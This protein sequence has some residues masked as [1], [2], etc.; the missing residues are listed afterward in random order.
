MIFDF[1]R[2]EDAFSSRTDMFDF[3]YPKY[4]QQIGSTFSYEEIESIIYNHYLSYQIC[5]KS[6]VKWKR[7]YL[8]PRMNEIMRKYN[9][10][11]ETADMIVEPLTNRNYTI[12]K[13]FT[14]TENTTGSKDSTSEIEKADATSGYNNSNF[15]NTKES[16]DSENRSNT[17]SETIGVETSETVTGSNSNSKKFSDTPQGAVTNLTNGYLTNVTLDDGS[18]S[19]STSGSSDTSNSKSESGETTSSSEATDTGENR[20]NFL[21][22]NSGSSNK[23]DSETTSKENSI[24]HESFEEIKGYDNMDAAKLLEDY[25][26]TIID[27]NTMLINDLADL[28]MQVYDYENLFEDIFGEESIEIPDDLPNG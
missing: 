18:N 21:T 7:Y 3:N 12:T 19:E 23:T 24:S 10:L 4:E 20:E 8:A 11:Y 27:I 25:R 6:P 14:E 5:V 22:A 28:F 2:V 26:R 16:S 15:T 9:K 17:A 13:E 1:P